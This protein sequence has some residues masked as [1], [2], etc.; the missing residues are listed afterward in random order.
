MEYSQVLWN[1]YWKINRIHRKILGE[2]PL[3]KE[4]VN[5]RWFPLSFGKLVWTAFRGSRPGVF[6][7][8][9]VLGNFAKFTGKHLCHLSFSQNTSRWLLLNVNMK[10]WVKSDVPKDVYNLQNLQLVKLSFDYQVN[11]VLI[12]LSWTSSERLMYVQ[13]TS[14]VYWIKKGLFL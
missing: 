7:K 10:N 9:G 8:K 2:I 3:L 6:C 1:S 11:V 5:H 12:K 4:C 13:F 14:C